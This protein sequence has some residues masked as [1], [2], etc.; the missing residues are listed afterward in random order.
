MR[1]G[2]RIP[3]A[4][5]TS[6]T[7]GNACAGFI[8]ALLPWGAR[9]EI[10][11]R[12]DF[13]ANQLAEAIAGQDWETGMLTLE[14]G[15]EEFNLDLQFNYRGCPS[16]FSDRRPTEREIIESGHGIRLLAGYLLRHSADSVRSESRGGMAHTWMHFDH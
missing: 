1:A 12:A 6:R 3:G 11:A 2:L 10:V 16:S 5:I 7:Q 9:P 15:F 13:A 14:A 4:P 8:Q